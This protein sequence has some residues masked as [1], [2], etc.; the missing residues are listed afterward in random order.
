MG[1]P[2]SFKDH[3]IMANEFLATGKG[4]C[5]YPNCRSYS[6]TCRFDN[7]DDE[8]KIHFTLSVLKGPAFSLLLKQHW[9]LKIPFSGSFDHTGK[10][11]IFVSGKNRKVMGDKLKF[12][13]ALKLHGELHA[14]LPDKEVPKLAAIH[15][16]NS[17]QNNLGSFLEN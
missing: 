1:C 7:K 16:V 5:T 2:I 13:S 3:N 9:K 6:F 14:K 17:E 10:P 8:N 15:K 4:K 11:R 12:E